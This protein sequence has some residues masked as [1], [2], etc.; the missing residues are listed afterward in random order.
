MRT[1]PRRSSGFTAAVSVEASIARKGA[2]R[3]IGGGAGRFSA[4]ISENC[5]LASPKGR[6]R[7]IDA[8]RQRPRRPL[9]GEAQ[10]G[11]AD[12]MDGRG[13]QAFRV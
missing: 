1:S 8:P 12:V 7:G 2:R 9:H 5:P 4:T 10:A 11:V 6:E 3:P 13:G